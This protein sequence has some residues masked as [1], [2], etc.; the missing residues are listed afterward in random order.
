MPKIDRRH[1]RGR[2]PDPF[3]AVGVLAIG[4]NLLI[5]TNWQPLVIALV[6]IWTACLYMARFAYRHRHNLTRSLLSLTGYGALFAILALFRVPFDDL[7]SFIYFIPALLGYAMPELA[8]VAVVGSTLT[9]L[10]FSY[11][12]EVG[13]PQTV[14]YVFGVVT[15]TILWMMIFRLLLRVETERDRYYRLSI[16]DSMTGL[17]TLGKALELGQAFLED[18]ECISLAIIDLDGFK[19]INDTY[20]HLAGNRVLTE[21][22]SRLS[23]AAAQISPRSVVGRLGGDEFVVIVPGEA[24]ADIAAS[25][26]TTL[27]RETYRPA[28]QVLPCLLPFSTGCAVAHAGCGTSIEELM[29]AADLAMY[30]NKRAA[31]DTRLAVAETAISSPFES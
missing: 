4:L 25:F 31:A 2:W 19:A 30:R 6:A 16:T 12:G 1:S 5:E 8:E 22:S 27:A 21:F 15:T 26:A 29:H 17:L 24:P 20:G 3:F 18:G 28:P 9:W 23:A 13:L 10:C 11:M 7:S 14:S